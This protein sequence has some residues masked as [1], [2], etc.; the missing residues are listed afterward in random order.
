M[1]RSK[2][3][4]LIPLLFLFLTPLHAQQTLL[5]SEKATPTE[6]IVRE[7]KAN[8]RIPMRQ[9]S[10]DGISTVRH[11]TSAS[12]ASAPKPLYIRGD[13]TTIWGNVIYANA[14]SSLDEGVTP[15]YGIYSFKSESNITMTP[16]TTYSSMIA[17]G[18]GIFHNGKFQFIYYFSTA[19]TDGFYATCS[20][21]DTKTW[22]RTSI[23]DVYDLSLIS[24]AGVSY[25]RTSDL[26]YGIFFTSDLK[27]FELGTIDYDKLTKTVIA[28]IN[29]HFVTFAIDN[30]GKAFGIDSLGVLY[31]IN[32]ETG[33]LTLVGNTGVTPDPGLQ[34]MTFDSQTG[35]LYWAT[36]T[37]GD[38]NGVLYEVSPQNGMA[39]KIA[40]LPDDEEIMCLYVPRADAL[41]AAP[42]KVTNLKANFNADATAG[43]VSFTAPVSSEKG[44][45]LTGNLTYYVRVNGKIA[46]TGTTTPGEAVSV[47]V[48]GR[49]GEN[50]IV[51]STANG[52][53]E[54]ATS[55][56]TLYLGADTP[57]KVSNAK[58][59]IDVATGNATIT[60]NS[61]QHG[62]NGGYIDKSKL[63]YTV[64]RYP[65]KDTVAKA[66][67]DTTFSE[68]VPVSATKNYYY[69]I[70]PAIG[71]AY[72]EPAQT[73]T[74]AIGTAYEVPYLQEFNDASSLKDFTTLD[75]NNDNR[76][77]DWN[78][79]DKAAYMTSTKGDA[80]DWLITPA[81]HLKSG[82]RYIF[83]FKAYNEV[84]FAHKTIEA[85]YGPTDDPTLMDTLVAPTTLTHTKT[86]APHI[87]RTVIPSEDG[88]YRFAIHDISPK[89]WFN[90]YVDSISVKLDAALAAPDTA[91]NLKAQAGERGALTASISF[92]APT[93][94]VAGDALESISEIVVLR[95][96]KDTVTTLDTAAPG[97][98]FTVN[99]AKSTQGLTK[100]TVI[101][102]N[103]N[104]SGA[105][106]VVNVWVGQDA[107]L[108]PTNVTLKDDANGHFVTSW[109]APGN[110][111]QHGG[112][113]DASQ[114]KYRLYRPN[115]YGSSSINVD[116]I[117]STS[118]S[119]SA[120]SFPSQQEI[121]Y[122]GL[123]AF[124]VGGESRQTGTPVVITGDVY[125]LPFTESFVN[126]KNQNFW[127]RTS[128]GDNGFQLTQTLP[129]DNDA[130]SAY[131]VAA[132]PGDEAWLNTGKISLANAANPK[133]VFSYFAY[134]GENAKLSIEV[135][136][137]TQSIVKLDEIDFTKLTGAA[138]WRQEIVDLKSVKDAPYISINFH[139]TSNATNVPV[140]FDAVKVYNVLGNDVTASVSAPSKASVGETVPVQVI[141]KN[142]GNNTAS[143]YTVHLYADE[144]ELDA[145]Q[146]KVIEPQQ[147]D[148]A[149]FQVTIRPNDPEVLKLYAVVDYPQDENTFDNTTDEAQI[150]VQQPDFPKVDNLTASDGGNGITLNWSKPASDAAPVTDDFESYEPFTISDFGNWKTVDGDKAQ[151]YTFS[152][153]TFP[154]SGVPTAFIAFNPKAANID[155]NVNTQLAP[156]SGDQYLA[157]FSSSADGGNDDWLIS[158]VLDG[159]AQTISFYA[160][161]ETS[162]YALEQFEVLYSTTDNEVGSFQ[163]IGSTFTA[164]ASDTAWTKFN[165]EIPQ[166]SK[167]FAIHVIT[168]DGFIFMLDDVSYHNGRLTVSGYNIYRDGELIATVG[169]D[170]T[171]F[172]D[173]NAG[174]GNHTYNVSVVY[175][176]GESG[177]SNN[178]SITNA[179]S[180]IVVEDGK[181]VRIYSV[182]GKILNKEQLGVNIEKSDDGNVRK[183]V[184]R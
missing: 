73:N 137:A 8:L 35:K 130:G 154:N 168:K 184:V 85:S 16:V 39:S 1:K 182:D 127:W 26:I 101:A 100:Y 129:A 117:A 144:K 41:D 176:V 109:T 44:D 31:N 136:K 25:D 69:Q 84:S 27:S 156:H 6:Q 118:Y 131:F 3:Y 21:F 81:I 165:V 119:V 102:S 45:L 67:A 14:W 162:R 124:N 20:T 18:G 125:I 36:A 49:H 83:S 4:I 59:T 116:S 138:G 181:V 13:G 15:P 160:K 139:A 23:K 28:P 72:G 148:T 112:Y 110:V 54:S 88:F 145:L 34:S 172:T 50:K 79:T 135:D 66:I 157:S 51:V 90:T 126:A 169:A 61:P 62:V 143:G 12:P 92:D 158:P 140:H 87:V 76:T 10:R 133:L 37:K 115:N 171:S 123:T 56:L 147:T 74:V 43:T 5:K 91:T 89:G 128:T 159:S 68:V 155:L 183:V 58:L 11:I 48:T 57:E 149:T 164:P 33:A 60:W 142:I 55:V 75:N 17:D 19:F 150:K 46:A 2:F 104:G 177:L 106:A 174:A 70:I 78:R 38:L 120:S 71:D 153:A 141:V 180:N 98:H 42:A 111:G 114:L 53:G 103:E 24:N 97:Q 94:T 64:I 95:N 134:P 173:T 107:P 167:Y 9:I 170:A 105:K 113:V 47:N 99:D 178:A 152:A 30:D 65:E 121:L 132:K 77:W 161:S 151:N 40:D 179:I 32:K 93:K 29:K 80:D 82:M 163:K 96:D 22:E 166:N 52:S 86:E 122:Y 175:T 7:S 146:G 63:R 108:A